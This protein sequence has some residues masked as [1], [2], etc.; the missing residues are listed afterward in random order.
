MAQR[1]L[2]GETAEQLGINRKTIR[3]YE[4]IGLIPNAARNDSGYRVFSGED[5][6]RLGFIL[7]AKTLGFS[8]DDIGE[9]LDLR[10]RG[11]AP[12]HYVADLIQE[13]IVEVDEKIADLHRLRSDLE[14]LTEQAKS[15]PSEQIVEK[16][17]I[18]RLIEDG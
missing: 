7:R 2:I 9:I 10:E 18:C 13:K 11:E 4:T 3:Y 14:Q 12:C 6:E 16:D 5:L 1:K 17:C 8:I 15:L